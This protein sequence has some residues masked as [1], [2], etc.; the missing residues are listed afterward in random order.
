MGNYYV[1]ATKAQLKL[2]S[3]MSAAGSTM[4][5]G[6]SPFVDGSILP[7]HPYYPEPAFTAARVPMMICSTL[8]EMAP[9]WTDSTLEN[10]TLDEVVEKVKDRAGFCLGWAMKPK[11]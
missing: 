5:R 2:N 1:I 3:E 7:Q 8:N 6:F 11:K 9:S 10:V 4:R